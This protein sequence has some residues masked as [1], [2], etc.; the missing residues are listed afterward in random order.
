MLLHT[1]AGDKVT[2]T[3]TALDVKGVPVGDSA[4]TALSL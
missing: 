1:A 4:G 2:L 3:L